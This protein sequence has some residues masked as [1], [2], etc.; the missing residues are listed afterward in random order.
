MRRAPRTLVVVGLLALGLA[1]AA[2]TSRA[3]AAETVTMRV[4]MSDGVELAARLSG[5]GPLVDGTLPARP[6]I[7]ELGPYGEASAIPATSPAYNHLYVQIRGTG[8]SDGAF[9]ALGDR[10]QRDVAEVLDWACRQPWSDGHLGL[11]GFSA[12]AI[13]AYHALHL[14]LPCVDAA[15]LGAGTHELYRDLLYPGGVPSIGPALVVLLG[16]GGGQLAAGPERLGRDPASGLETI[17]GMFDSGFA[18][19][20]HP[21]EDAWWQ[22]RSMRGNVN[23]FPILMVTGMF[24]VESRGPFQV[25]QELHDRQPQ[26][27]HYVVGAHDG[28]P[29]GTGGAD[30]ERLA[31]YDHHLRGVDNGVEDHPAVSLW[32]A[33]GDREGLLAGRFVRVDG[34]DWPLPGT[35][36]RAYH[37]DAT[38]SGSATSLN[39]GTLAAAP[40]G[41]AAQSYA[42]VPSSATATDPNTIATVGVFNSTP[43]TDLRLVEPLALTYTT[44]PFA[45][46]VVAAGPAAVELLLSS[47]VPESDVHVVLADVAPDGSSH[48]V[49]MGKLRT[50][51]PHIDP[52][53]SLVDD[54]GAVVQPYGR[55]DAK[56]P[57]PIGQERRYHVEVWPV[58]NRF[59]A[60][61]RLRLYVVG[62]SSVSVPSL[63]AV[64]TV[65]LGGPDGSK[66]LFPVLPAAATAPPPSTTAPVEGGLLPVT[67]RA[68]SGL[69]ALLLLVA[70]L[71]GIPVVRRSGFRGPARG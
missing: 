36:W 33:D 38:R 65:R 43:L 15:V 17:E 6:T 56:D 49:G 20:E 1:L 11:W 35:E 31:W 50:S 66:L 34:P 21:T 61:H 40:A 2:P 67:G 52:A 24:D 51:Y 44:P 68:T 9:D 26:H 19:L 4:A 54:A 37:L 29:A 23:D 5:E 27:H 71:A 46:D 69:A 62:P 58:G 55:F 41:P 45:Q 25:F 60:G 30:A 22:E 7:V 64:N 48:P 10:S 13:M 70:G 18:F 59:K 3:A 42:S 12:S 47:T 32:L 53:R 14:E 63:P 57:A 39:D 28:V 8:T 16:I